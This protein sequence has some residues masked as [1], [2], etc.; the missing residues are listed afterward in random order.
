MIWL[1]VFKVAREVA[2]IRLDVASVRRA[3]APTTVGHVAAVAAHE[4][5][6]KEEEE[7]EQEGGDSG[8]GCGGVCGEGGIY[9]IVEISG[10]LLKHWL[11]EAAQ[12]A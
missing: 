1:N 11:D 5:A 10:Q 7:G 9:V 4:I 3:T 12:V 8:A 2:R 6:I